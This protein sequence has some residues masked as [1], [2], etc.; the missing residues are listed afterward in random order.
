MEEDVELYMATN[1]GIPW[2]CRSQELYNQHILLDTFL[3]VSLTL[4][5]SQQHFRGVS[6][7]NWNCMHVCIR[8][9][10]VTLSDF[11]SVNLFM[12]THTKQRYRQ[13]THVH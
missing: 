3:L 6:D 10:F 4:C 5:T 2:R 1:C 11:D 13:H 9:H 12:V 7:V 8:P